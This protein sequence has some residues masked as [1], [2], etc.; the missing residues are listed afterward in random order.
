MRIDLISYGRQDLPSAPHLPHFEM[1]GD[2]AHNLDVLVEQPIDMEAPPHPFIE[3]GRKTF[4]AL[5]QSKQNVF[6]GRLL[7][8]DA[9]ICMLIT[10]SF[11]ILS[12]CKVLTRILRRVEL[13]GRSDPTPLRGRSRQTPS[14]FLWSCAIR[15]EHSKGRQRQ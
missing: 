6:G 5:P 8:C 2:S 11:T 15:T 10:A 1:L 4:D 9:T 14:P 12:R 7:I 13:A 3:Q